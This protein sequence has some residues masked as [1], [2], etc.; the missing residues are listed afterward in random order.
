VDKRSFLIGTGAIVAGL[1]GRTAAQ[2]VPGD[3]L[4]PR[5]RYGGDA[6]FAPFE[7]LDAQGRP[8]GFQIDLVQA[9]SRQLG[10]PIDVTLAPWSDTE[11]AFR[12]GAVD[13]IAMVDIP[14]RREWARFLRGHATPAIAVYRLRERPPVQGLSDLAGLR[15]AVPDREV[16][17]A[18]LDTWLPELRGRRIPVNDSAEAFAALRE[19][20]ADAA[21]VLRAYGDPELAAEREAAAEDDIVSS[22]LDL[23]LQTYAFAVA[24]GRD[25]LRTRLQQA[26]DALDAD[27]TLE[28]LRTRWLGSYRDIAA[29]QLAE[30]QLL[31]QRTWTWG[32]AGAS[33]LALIGMTVGLRRIAL[34]ATADRRRRREAEAALKHARELLDRTFGSHPDAMLFVERGSGR[35]SDANRALIAVLGTT[36]EAVIGQPLAQLDRHIDAAVLA[37]LVQSLDE[38]GQLEAVPVTLTNARGEARACLLSAERMDVDGVPQVF[39]L[40]RD[41]TDELARDAAM[42]SGYAQ[43]V[44]DLAHTRQALVETSEARDSARQRLDDYTRALSHDL[45]EPVFAVQ[46][47]AGMLQRRL[48]AG[49]VKE[50]MRHAE[51]IER[52]AE[53]MSAMIQALTRLARVAEVVPMRSAVN[54][55]E[56]AAE[57][58]RLMV[59]A[60]PDRRV[61]VR[62]DELP[63]AQC[64]AQLLGH[65]WHHLLDN[66][67]KYSAVQPDPKVAVDSHVEA[68]RTWYRVT[69]NGIGFDMTRAGGLFVP[70]QRLHAGAAYEGAGIGL[71]VVQR[72]VEQHGGEVRLRSAP[73][74][75]TVAEFTLQPKA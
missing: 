21:L 43:L 45:K 57:Q 51:T 22:T 59:A 49:H 20:R 41:I 7:S 5:L 34:R 33:A 38:Q 40:V 72:I 42:R 37:W 36:S 75:G 69:D 58:W 56:L 18:T 52:A 62:I 17:L 71:S 66:A 12:D 55:R 1:A 70:F 44:A 28:R 35:V 9:M 15:I 25:G 11:G 46:G 50:A 13:L 24:P 19:G 64:D 73:D 3:G 74:V 10:V 68:G 26:L 29:R 39:C 63:P 23:G 2:S 16:M 53:R 61:K 31:S 65:V 4:P 14:Q 60:H 47:F 27:G 67:A 32:I 48:Q 8:T 6:A 54:M 30:R